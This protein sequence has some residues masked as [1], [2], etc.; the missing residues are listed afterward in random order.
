MEPKGKT[1]HLTGWHFRTSVGQRFGAKPEMPTARSGRVLGFAS[2]PSLAPLCSLF[3]CFSL[4]SA[5]TAHS[6]AIVAPLHMLESV[7]TPV[8]HLSLSSLRS[9]IA[10]CLT[11]VCPASRIWSG[12]TIAA[13]LRFAWAACR[14]CGPMAAELTGNAPLWEL[15]SRGISSLGTLFC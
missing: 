5:Q 14:K 12:A 6:L 3:A 8:M 7:H 9:S 4:R 11:S 10:R 15:R 1:N 2:R 13:K